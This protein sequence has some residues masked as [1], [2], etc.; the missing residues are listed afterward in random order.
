MPNWCENSLN[1]SHT[2]KSKIDELEAVLSQKDPNVFQFLRPRP[3]DQEENW[4]DWN[5]EHWG[6]KWDITPHHF[7]RV[8]E[9]A[10]FLTFD[11]AWNPPVALYDYLSE[12]GW[13]IYALYHEGGMGFAGRYEDGVD[14][15]Y[16]YSFDSEE[17][18]EALPTD[19]IEFGG[20]WEN[21]EFYKESLKEDENNE[22]TN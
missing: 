16:E 10:I 9:N 4:Y 14:D 11:S 20:I 13:M 2:D 17:S 5:I 15:Y 7:E 1:I 18:I 8:T 12:Q 22:N 6:T 3:A 19:L 21:Y